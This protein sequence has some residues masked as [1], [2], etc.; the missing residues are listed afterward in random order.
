MDIIGFLDNLNGVKREE[1]DVPQEGFNILK[2]GYMTIY[3]QAAKGYDGYSKSKVAMQ[4]HGF[5]SILLQQKYD[6]NTWQDGHKGANVGEYHLRDDL[7][8]W[9]FPYLNDDRI[10]TLRAVGIIGDEAK[11]VIN[12]W[13]RFPNLISQ[14]FKEILETAFKFL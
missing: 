6:R 14:E 13:L 9:Y 10:D 4:E 12:G 7:T 2:T 8:V 3:S 5:R 1:V 11:E